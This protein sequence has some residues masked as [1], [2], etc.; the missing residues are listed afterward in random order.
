M[1][2]REKNSFRFPLPPADLRERVGGRNDRI[3]LNFL[4]TG[5]ALLLDIKRLLKRKTGRHFDTFRNALDFG[6]GCGRVAIWVPKESGLKV[7]GVDVDAEAIRW[8]QANLGS[9]GTFTKVEPM[10]PLP[11]ENET[12]DL[13]Y[14][15]SVFSHLPE[16]MEHSWLA[17]L[18]RVLQ[19]GGILLASFHTEEYFPAGEGTEERKEFESRGFCYTRGEPTPGLPDYY[20]TSFH[21]ESYVQQHWSRWYSILAVEAEAINHHQ[22]VAVCERLAK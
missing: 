11:F 2:S 16:E 18:A 7:T 4:A 21:R 22:G 14:A 10:P 15:I 19:P 8:C 12:F 3:P 9:V 5:A 17:E 1:F 13:I 20:Q 6:C